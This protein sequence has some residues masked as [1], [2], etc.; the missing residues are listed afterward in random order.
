MRLLILFLFFTIPTFAQKKFII[1]DDTNAA[2]IGASVLLM[3]EKNNLIAVS[4]AAGTFEID[5]ID[6]ANYLIHS[7]GYV[8]AKFSATQ[9]KIHNAIVLKTVSYQLKEVT[10]GSTLSAFAIKQTRTSEYK[11]ISDFPQNAKIQ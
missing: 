4:N 6:T 10:A 7:L 3:G 9:L 5:V 8:D 1:T 11:T 2:I